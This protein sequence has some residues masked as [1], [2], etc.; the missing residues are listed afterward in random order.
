MFSWSFIV[1][2]LHK[3]WI[4]CGI[5]SDIINIKVKSHN[6]AI[7]IT[8]RETWVCNVISKKKKRLRTKHIHVKNKKPINHFWS[9][10]NHPRAEEDPDPYK[11]MPST[12]QTRSGHLMVKDIGT[13]DDSTKFM[14][15]NL[16]GDSKD[17]TARFIDRQ[18]WF[19]MQRWILK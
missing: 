12:S 16:Q 9:L 14:I 17:S 2:Y 8:N 6:I 19:K 7:Q 15:S 5:K 10:P 18:F 3:M 1:V 4:T 11:D 13:M